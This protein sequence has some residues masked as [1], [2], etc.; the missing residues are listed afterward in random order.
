MTRTRAPVD[1]EPLFARIVDLVQAHRALN[2]ADLRAARRHLPALTPRLVERG[3]EV[4]SNVRVPLAAQIRERLQRGFALRKGLERDVKGGTAREVDTALRGL[5]E[6]GEIVATFR[7]SGAGFLAPDSDVLPAGDL[8]ELLRCLKNVEKLARRARATRSVCGT[9]GIAVTLLREDVTARL[10]RF[11]GAA[12][13]PSPAA[14][15]STA[16]TP[17]L[18]TREIIARLRATPRPLRVP[19]LIRALHDLG[20]ST[21]E[22]QRA[23]LDGAARGLFELQ[24]ESG[25]GRLSHDDAALCPRGPMGTSL[26]WVSA[27]MQKE[28]SP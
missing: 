25:M 23:L 5:L 22:G 10:A 16:V 28:V 12:P 9:K 17:D 8:E 15:G 7:E 26:S 2:A 11:T 3:L 19:D 24:P 1:L 4:G 27:R 21:A 14:N 6:R 18:I 20:A 13:A